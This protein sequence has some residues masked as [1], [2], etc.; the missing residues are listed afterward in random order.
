MDIEQILLQHNIEFPLM[1]ADDYLKLIFQSEFGC[2]HMVE[3]AQSALESLQ[4]ECKQLPQSR[5]ELTTTVSD[6]FTRVN[7]AEFINTMGDPTTLADIFIASSKTKCGTAE[8][9]AAKCEVFLN[10]VAGKKID[11]PLY[12]T[13]KQVAKFI[14]DLRA[15]H[16]S[17][18]YRLNY[19]PHYRVVRRDL[20]FVYRIIDFISARV[21]N[22]QKTFIA[23]D[24]DSSSGKSYFG[25]ILE[26]YYGDKCLLIHADDFFLPIELRSN[27]RLSEIGGNLHYERVAELLKEL[28]GGSNTVK[29]YKYDCHENKMI[30]QEAN[31]RPVVIVEGV[32]SANSR[33]I[34]FYDY[35]LMLTVNK[36]LQQT[37]I[38]KRDGEDTLE[39]YNKIWLPLEQK[40]LD[41]F[42]CDSAFS[43][44]LSTDNEDYLDKSV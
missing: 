21:N 7:L 11:L 5:G 33:L 28:K 41:D 17:M 6:D 23:I 3:D 37:R 27:E 13:K 35:V 36:K 8:A 15:V 1:R 30:E 29:Y 26:Q 2:E 19:Q 14:A 16:H 12:Q 10:L 25:R 42:S 18:T 39:R 31:N 20:F 24:G 4:L 40:Y 34:G 32:Y 38:L 43:V 44:R 22:K 9:L